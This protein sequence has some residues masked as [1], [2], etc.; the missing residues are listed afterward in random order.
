MSASHDPARR[1]WR[2]RRRH[3]AIDAVL[4]ARPSGCEL[5]YVRNGRVLVAWPFDSPETAVREAES[6]LDA[7]QRAG[8]TSHW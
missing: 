8:W 4:I 2:A 6:R 3:D 5:R 7:L 1:L